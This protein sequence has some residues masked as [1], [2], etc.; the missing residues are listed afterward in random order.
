MYRK[1]IPYLAKYRALLLGSSLCSVLEAIFELTIPLLLAELLDVGVV[2][3]NIRYTLLLGAGMLGLAVLV[4]FCG[5]LSIR[6]AT[7]AGTGFSAD[8]RQAQ[9]AHVQKFSFRSLEKFGSPSL[10]TRMTTDVTATQTAMFQCVKQVVRSFSMVLVAAIMAC[11]LSTQ[12]S[13]MFVVLVPVM[14]VLLVVIVR[15][16]R[17]LYRELQ[18]QT[19]V[20]NR[21][22]QENLTGIRTVKAYVRQRQ[23]MTLFS[24][25]NGGVFRASDRAYGLSA[26]STP[27]M[28]LFTYG[29]MLVLLG[30]GGS[31]VIGGQATIGELTG[32]ITYVT[33]IFAQLLSFSNA[34]LLLNR[35]MISAQRINEVLDEQPELS[36]GGFSGEV[37][38]GEVEF[39]H[40]TFSY[41][42]GGPVLE[43]ISFRAKAGQ[44][45]GIV[46]GTGSSKSTLVQMIPR[47]YDV[48]SGA[49]RVGGRDVREYRMD[50]LRRGVAIVLQTNTLFSGTI[51]ENLLWGDEDA[52]DAEL[53]AACRR[54]AAAEFIHRF[55][56]GYD[57]RLGQDG[58]N[59]SGGQRQR[60][61]LARAL[62]QRPKVLI[63]DDSTSAVDMQTDAEIWR[64]LRSL[65]DTTVFIIAQR[66]RSVRDA[67][68]I[69]VMDQGGISARGSHDELLRCSEIYRQM[70]ISQQE[71]GS[72]VEEQ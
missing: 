9:F 54:S 43:N 18:E 72:T 26:I 44:V 19:D 40:V 45:I 36:D 68:Q 39:D 22:T 63:L 11:R 16:S 60:L 57:T 27:M 58:V 12:L 31:L 21:V 34:V 70:A 24:Q 1:L 42:A 29:A 66:I 4:F 8:L 25:A 69:L 55:P 30:Y 41:S 52:T 64:G 6:L 28:T 59:L 10:I 32:F 47:L 5:I 3:G 49:V 15:R 67:D 37:E 23:Q 13:V 50:R 14:A 20:L 53:E 46:G 38:N 35:S 33:Q 56:E 17:P 51:R 7:K 48:D 71:G 2:S 65:T 62:L 61:C